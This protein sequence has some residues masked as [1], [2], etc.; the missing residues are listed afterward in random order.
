[1]DTEITYTEKT[2]KSNIKGL[3][4][5]S[6]IKFCDEN[7]I[8]MNVLENNKLTGHKDFNNDLTIT[9]LFEMEVGEVKR[10]KNNFITCTDIITEVL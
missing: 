5:F 9:S 10:N 3:K 4:E 2:Y 7:T 1:M 6:L 8:T